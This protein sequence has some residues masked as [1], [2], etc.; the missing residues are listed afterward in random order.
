MEPATAA[1]QNIPPLAFFVGV[2]LLR[3]AG[4]GADSGVGPL[5][6]LPVCWL[7][8]YGGRAALT[9]SLVRD[10]FGVLRTVAADRRTRLP[11][12]GAAPRTR[13]D[14]GRRAGRLSPSRVWCARCTSTAR[15]R[16]RPRR[17]PPQAAEQLAAVAQVRH[18]MQVNQDPREV[19]CEGARALLRA[20]FALPARARGDAHSAAHG[21]GGL[22]AAPLCPCRWTRPAPPPPTACSA[23][24]DSSSP[25]RAPTR[26]SR[27]S[28]RAQVGAVSLLYEPVVRRGQV[29]AVLVVGW[30]QRSFSAMRPRW[31]R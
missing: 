13:A 15:R 17:R 20:T 11:R 22:R 6:L 1:A 24:A 18:S 30:H 29:V 7:A 31:P 5:V 23:G 19:I 2:V 25:T 10:R 3:D 12:C 9:A 4:G 8:L 21:R 26:G 14:V 16:R 27:T 28:L